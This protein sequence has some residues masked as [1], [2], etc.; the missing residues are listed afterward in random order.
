MCGNSVFHGA[1]LYVFLPKC[2]E[3]GTTFPLFTTNFSSQLCNVRPLI[4]HPLYGMLGG[5]GWKMEIAT[6][7]PSQ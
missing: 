2:F 1:G 4:L 5:K 6:L 7:L 3:K